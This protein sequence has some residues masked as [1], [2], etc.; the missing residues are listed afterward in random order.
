MSSVDS[1]WEA[2]AVA[3][4]PSP[5]YKEHRTRLNPTTRFAR[6]GCVQ[7]H[8]K[9]QIYLAC[10]RDSKNSFSQHPLPKGF[11][12]NT[13]I[14]QLFKHIFGLPVIELPQNRYDCEC[15]EVCLLEPPQPVVV[16]FFRAGVNFSIENVKFR[17]IVTNFWAILSG[18]F[19]PFGL[20]NVA[21]YQNGQI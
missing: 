2:T 12:P 17:P 8:V 21:V 14:L 5:H 13:K 10:I 16:N 4:Q 7:V 19:V 9:G 20:N 6:C 3:A 11:F 15:E 18:I 1:T